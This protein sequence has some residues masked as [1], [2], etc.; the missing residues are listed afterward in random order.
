MRYDASDGKSSA[1]FHF[2]T[3]LRSAYILWTDE[4]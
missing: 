1:R 4:L 3:G 2:R